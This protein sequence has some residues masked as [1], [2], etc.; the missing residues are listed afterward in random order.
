MSS[1]NGQMNLQ[2]KEQKEKKCCTIEVKRF[3]RDI[4][5]T[6]SYWSLVRNSE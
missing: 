4:N 5:A 6:V 3:M 2:I 1:F